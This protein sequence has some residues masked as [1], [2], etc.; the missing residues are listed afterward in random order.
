VSGRPWPRLPAEPMLKAVERLGGPSKL[1]PDLKRTY[2][3]AKARGTVTRHS[4]V[5]LAR[6]IGDLPGWIWGWDAWFGTS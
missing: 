4:A 2:Y 6:H 5:R 1:P 3:R